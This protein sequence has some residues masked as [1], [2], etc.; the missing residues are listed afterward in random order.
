MSWDSLATL[1]LNFS[2]ATSKPCDLRQVTE[3]LGASGVVSV[4]RGI[5]PLGGWEDSLRLCARMPS[6][7]PA[8]AVI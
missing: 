7:R 5:H 1:L 8:R 2:F 3:S 6:P 4:K